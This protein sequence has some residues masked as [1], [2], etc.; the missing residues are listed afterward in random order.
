MKAA[1]AQRDRPQLVQKT[2]SGIRAKL[3]RTK[4]SCRLKHFRKMLL[5]MNVKHPIRLLHRLN[6][7]AGVVAERVD[8]DMEHVSRACRYIRRAT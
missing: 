2:L 7:F 6:I 5:R 3:K 4:R 8:G 1:L